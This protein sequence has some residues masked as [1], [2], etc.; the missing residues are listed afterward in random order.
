MNL[1]RIS[2][3]NIWDEIKRKI[4]LRGIKD[5]SINLLKDFINSYIKNKF[6]FNWGLNVN[7]IKFKR[8]V[9]L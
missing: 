8:Y 3:I 9:K 1:Q 4:E 5:F 6:N 2:E 7:K